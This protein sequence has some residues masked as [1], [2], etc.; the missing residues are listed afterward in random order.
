MIIGILCALGCEFFYG[1]SYIFTKQ[2]TD[3]V[4]TFALLGWRFLIAVAVMSLL[5]F[6]GVIKVNLKGKPVK[7]LLLI[8]L[9]FPCIY[10]IGETLGIN[11]TTASESSVFMACIPVAS[12]VASATILKKYP[13]KTQ[14]IGILITF[15]GVIITVWAKGATSTMS[16]GGY[17]FLLLALIS[18]ALYSVF[19]DKAIAYTSGEITYIM[20]VLGAAVFLTIALAEALIGGT[21]KEF[22]ALPVSNGSFLVT[23]L[24]QGIGC[25]I[26]AFFM[27]NVAIAKLGVNCT[28]SFAGLATVVSLIASAIV[29]QERF[30]PWQLIGAGVILGGVYTANTKPKNDTPGAGL[31]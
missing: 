17:A 28:A 14:I 11:Y 25:S 30:T 12:L 27:A 31:A 10:F 16:A 5:V 13:T 20:L 15:A 2:A 9:L 19:V 22:I 7:P 4:S 26:L 8:A 23:I 21:M 1:L 6:L 18:Y 3:Q 24:Y 29:L